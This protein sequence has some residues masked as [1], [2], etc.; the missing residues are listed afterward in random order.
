MGPSDGSVRFFVMT[1]ALNVLVNKILYIDLSIFFKK[2]ERKKRK[3]KVDSGSLIS[4][5]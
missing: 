4:L 3:E 1:T 5:M 2:K